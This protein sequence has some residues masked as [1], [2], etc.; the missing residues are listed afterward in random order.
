MSFLENKYCFV[1]GALS[2]EICTIS[3]KYALIKKQIDFSP[4][5]IEN[6]EQTHAVYS[7]SLIESI[8]W[9]LHPKIEEVTNLK[10]YPTYSF[11]RVYNPGDS[12]EIHTDRQEC[13]ISATLCL[14]YNY[15]TKTPNYNWGMYVKPP[16]GQVDKPICEPGDMI[17]YKGIEVEHWRDVFSTDEGS[18]Q[19]QAFLHYVDA[20]GPLAKFKYDRRPAIGLPIT[21]RINL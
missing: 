8:L 1:K 6:R 10:L 15:I 13:E 9:F 7:D 3:T 4:E 20:N 17:V 18:Y 5:N 19:V 16:H 2:K 21:S 12:L 14:G 11:Y